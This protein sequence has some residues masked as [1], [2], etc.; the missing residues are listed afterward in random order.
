MQKQEV[1]YLDHLALMER[2]K[3]YA[4]PKSKL[5]QMVRSGKLI[6]IRRGLYIDSQE[7]TYSIKTLANLICYPS[8]ISFEYALSFYDM[9]PE[10]VEMITSAS[11]QKNKNKTFHTLVGT[12]IYYYLQ[13]S[14]YPFG[15][16]R[17]EENGQPYLIATR[18]KALLDTLSKIRGVRSIKAMQN[19]IVEDLRLDE[20]VLHDLDRQEL[21]LLSSK[22][23]QRNCRMF[24]QWL[25]RS[26][27]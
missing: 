14:V 10:K 23:H 26:L 21:S 24:V 1:T 3:S 2:F 7:S 12:F 4:S 11:F 20:D 19:L 5:T 27:K 18:E 6:K 17:L 25:E 8:Y 9:I 22:Y 16:N 13:P 15:I